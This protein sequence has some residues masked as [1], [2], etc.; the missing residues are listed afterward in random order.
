ML[1]E[2]RCLRSPPVASARRAPGVRCDPT[3]VSIVAAKKCG[4]DMLAEYRTHWKWLILFQSSY[5]F[6]TAS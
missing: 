2:Q 5:R 1:T 4:L 3:K 6:T